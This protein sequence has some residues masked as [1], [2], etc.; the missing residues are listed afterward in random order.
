MSDYSI[1]IKNIE[2]IES[3]LASKPQLIPYLSAKVTVEITSPERTVVIEVSISDRKARTLDEA[4]MAALVAVQSF[5]EGIAEA[6]REMV[7]AKKYV[8]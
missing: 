2:N 3:E 4:A 8:L 6:A 7:Q 1:K 5:G